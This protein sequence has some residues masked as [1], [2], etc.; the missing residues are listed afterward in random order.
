MYAYLEINL[1]KSN[2]AWTPK[3]MD[4]CKAQTCQKRRHTHSGREANRMG[5]TILFITLIFISIF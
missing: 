5:V 3:A 1:M 4:T 2:K